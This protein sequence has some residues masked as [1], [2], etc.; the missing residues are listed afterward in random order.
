[1]KYKIQSNIIFK[2]IV[3]YKFIFLIFLSFLI[4][5]PLE[6]KNNES[7]K[8]FID[9]LQKC[10][11]EKEYNVCK[12]S[13]IELEKLQEEK[14]SIQ[15]YPCQTRLLGIQSEIIMTMNTVKKYNIK[16]QNF[17]EIKNFCFDSQ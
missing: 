13:L 8:E 12:E 2:L 10:F 5:S 14:S 9:L 16:K 17:E 7:N 3:N 6:S 15:N 11:L 4:Y 1:M